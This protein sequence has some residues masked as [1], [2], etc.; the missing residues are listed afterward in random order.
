M[1]VSRKDGFTLLFR[2]S[3][4][5]VGLVLIQP[6]RIGRKRTSI[7]LGSGVA[8]PASG[9]GLVRAIDVDGRLRLGRVVDLLAMQGVERLADNGVLLPVDLG[10]VRD[11]LGHEGVLPGEV[12]GGAGALGGVELG[13]ESV[14]V[15]DGVGAVGVEEADVLVGPFALQLQD[16]YGGAESDGVGVVVKIDGLW[17]RS[18]LGGLLGEVGGVGE[19]SDRRDGGC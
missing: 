11:G 15:G 1:G 19:V 13:D 17:G 18:R 2:L 4:G 9:P 14:R 16:G 10:A 7:F 12:G 3:L 5:G 6:R 8:G